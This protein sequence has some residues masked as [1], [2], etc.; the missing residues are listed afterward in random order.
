MPD[1]IALLGT[2]WALPV[3]IA[4]IDGQRRFSDIQRAV[5]G[6]SAK[7]LT[8]RLR[9]LEAASLVAREPLPPPAV[10]QAY[11]L[12]VAAEGLRPAL[13]NLQDWA[14][15]VRLNPAAVL[16]QRDRE[17][18]NPGATEVHCT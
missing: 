6:I 16:R 14:A 18:S 15:E 11:M 1:M 5:D 4:L 17:R 2:R 9:E 7:S 8:Q 12:G 3:L 13:R 10:G